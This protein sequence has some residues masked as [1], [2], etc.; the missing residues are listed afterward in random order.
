[1]VQ[2][3]DVAK[4]F[5]TIRGVW[6]FFDAPESVL[7]LWVKVLADVTP[8]AADE[9]LEQWCATESKPPTPADIRRLATAGHPSAAR[10]EQGEMFRPNTVMLYNRIDPETGEVTRLG[11]PVEVD[12]AEYR[13]QRIEQMRGTGTFVD[14]GDIS[15]S[16]PVAVAEAVEDE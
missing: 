12:R 8:A 15:A 4:L 5:L 1:M 9:A 11:E 3:S 16:S 13:R 2:R 14:L 10:A 7:T 6:G